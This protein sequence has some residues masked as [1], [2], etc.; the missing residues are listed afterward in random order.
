MGRVCFR[1]SSAAET[2]PRRP[3]TQSE[4]RAIPIQDP[5][6]QAASLMTRGR[7]PLPSRIVGINNDGK[8]GWFC[9]HKR[10]IELLLYVF[11]TPRHL[12]RGHTRPPCRALVLSGWSTYDVARG[13]TILINTPKPRTAL[14]L[15]IPPP[16][17]S[18]VR[19]LPS[20]PISRPPLPYNPHAIS[21]A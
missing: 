13:L 6:L 3:L 17:Y 10:E 21:G 12:F 14:V 1:V 2:G 15:Y 8:W 18:A 7:F 9:S 16:S 4:K 5:I 20:T 11:Q 19:T